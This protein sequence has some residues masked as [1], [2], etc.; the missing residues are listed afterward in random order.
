M[1][2]K[3]T[4][5]AR[6]LM[7]A[8]MGTSIAVLV[9]TCAVFVIYEYVTFRKTVV[10]GLIVRAEIIA[11]NSTAALAFEDETDAREVLSALANDPHMVAACIY[12]KDGRV[13]AK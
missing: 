8:I 11:A 5:I 12:D 4:T 9:L 13:F 3:Q 1:S 7:R 6:K 2:S 10:R